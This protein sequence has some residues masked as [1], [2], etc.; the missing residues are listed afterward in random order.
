MKIAFLFLKPFLLSK[1]TNNVQDIQTDK[2]PQFS[3]SPDA[4]ML[5]VCF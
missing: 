1:I 3:A 4:N 5:L 2:L